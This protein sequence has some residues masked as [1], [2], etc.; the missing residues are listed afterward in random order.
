M[1][2]RNEREWS[3]LVTGHHETGKKERAHQF[4]REITPSE[5]A[6]WQALRANRLG[7]LHFRRQQ[8]IDG[9]I[10][11]FYCHAAGLVVELDGSVHVRRGPQRIRRRA[12]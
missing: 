11:D 8:I 6:L 10:A 3:G 4:R 12:G 5:A 2:R 7:G 1:E 9:F